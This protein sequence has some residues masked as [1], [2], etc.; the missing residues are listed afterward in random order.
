MSFE[1]LFLQQTAGARSARGGWLL[2]VHTQRNMN[3]CV[4]ILR[5]H[6][7]NLFLGGSW[8]L[9][10]HTQRCAPQQ[11][12]RKML[13]NL[14]YARWLKSTPLKEQCVAVCCSVLQWVAV[15]CRVLM[16]KEHSIA[17][18]VC[19]SVLQC[20]AVC[21]SVLQW[22]AVSCRELMI[23]EHSRHAGADY[24]VFILRR[25]FI[26]KIYF[27]VFTPTIKLY[28]YWVFILR[29]VFIYFEYEYWYFEYSY[30]QY[31]FTYSHP[32]F[33]FTIRDSHSQFDFPDGG[34]EIRILEYSYSDFIFTIFL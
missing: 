20:V 6:F 14:P 7:H 9:S 12:H 8:L 34:F 30:S 5:I 10:I 1:N 16:V 21:C 24:W 19:C 28:Y 11:P 15:S 22:V 2:S 25:V 27:H 13:L 26:L 4:L 29:R 32:Q 23:K 3:I 33:V 17:R 18:T 31:I